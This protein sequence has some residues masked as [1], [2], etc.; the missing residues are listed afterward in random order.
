MRM[1]I[2]VAFRTLRW[3]DGSLYQ[4][5]SL[6]FEAKGVGYGL[7]HGVELDWSLGCRDHESVFVHIYTTR[8]QF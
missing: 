7:D 4:I 3:R 2:W 6:Y 5:F 8:L 1:D